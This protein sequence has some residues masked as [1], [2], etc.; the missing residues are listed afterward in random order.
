MTTREAIVELLWHLKNKR[1]I[2]DVEE[3]FVLRA[4]DREGKRPTK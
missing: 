4:L 1:I 3:N 2:S